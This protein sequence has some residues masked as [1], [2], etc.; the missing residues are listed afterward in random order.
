MTVGRDLRMYSSDEVRKWAKK[1]KL[2]PG[3][4]RG[5]KDGIQ[6]V[7]IGG[8]DKIEEIEWELFDAVLKKKRLAVYGT[9]EGWMRIM[10]RKT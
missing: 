3:K 4:V 6:F 7:A 9:R 10:R 5:T 2:S 1:K 8:S